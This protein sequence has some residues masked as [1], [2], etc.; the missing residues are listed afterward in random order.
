MGGHFVGLSAPHGCL[1]MWD[2]SW[3]C[4]SV[5]P[6]SNQ[7]CS[8]PAGSFPQRP[9]PIAGA[10]GHGQGVP[11][12]HEEEDPAPGPAVAAGSPTP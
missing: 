5:M 2:I 9:G 3:L 8:I 6:D 4:D 12:L 1:P 11:Q 10:G 7:Q